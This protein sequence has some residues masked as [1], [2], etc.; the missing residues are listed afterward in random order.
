MKITVR[1]QGNMCFEAEAE[2][3]SFTINCPQISPVEYFLGG[4]ITCSATDMIQMPKKQGFEVENLEI[5]GDALRNDQMPKKF[6]KLYLI[7]SF[8]SLAQDDM[9]LKWVMAS[10]ETYCS[11]INTIRDSVKI[12]Y[13][14]V[15]NGTIIA[16]HKEL[17]SGG[18]NSTDFG[19]IGGC[20]A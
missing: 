9:A 1:D 5:S 11:T 8:N 12:S 2:S 19:D 14:V 10:L 4:I 7:Y 20:P 3:G 17:I 16:D 13:S 18:G 15:H 6:N